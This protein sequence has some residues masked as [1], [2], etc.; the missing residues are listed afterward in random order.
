MK[1]SI[2]FFVII[3]QFTYPSNAT[4]NIDNS[5]S[6]EKIET[7]NFDF[8]KLDGI[9]KLKRQILRNLIK[10][11]LI[12]SKK[13]FVKIELPKNKIIINGKTLDSKL[14]NKYNSIFQNYEIQHGEHREI[15]VSPRFIKVGDF[16]DDCFKGSAYGTVKLKICDD[17]EN[18][19]SLFENNK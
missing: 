2:L 16:Y 12:E 8:I 18:K 10:D 7:S 11:G 6:F 1:K 13:E 19:N 5:I 14:F 4:L 17:N 15:H 3:F 9:K